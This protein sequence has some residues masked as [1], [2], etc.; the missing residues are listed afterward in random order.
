[1]KK[2]LWITALLCP[3]LAH[4]QVKMS[5]H[6]QVRHPAGTRQLYFF[7]RRNQIP[8]LIDS[9]NISSDG[10]YI[11]NLHLK[12]EGAYLVGDRMGGQY[13]FWATGKDL[14]MD[15]DEQEMPIVAN[16][17]DNQIVHQVN[18]AIA[19]RTKDYGTNP[20]QALQSF[21]EKLTVLIRANA[22]HPGVLYP[23]S[24]FSF[25]T[26]SALIGEILPTL[27]RKNPS[28]A[29]V[30]A[31]AAA[32]VRLQQG[33]PAP[34]FDFVTP[35]GEKKKL[36]AALT[37]SK[38]VLVDFWASWCG[39]CR[40]GIPGIKK[41]YDEYKNKGLDVLAI[42]LDAKEEE[43]K[44]ALAE[45]E[46][47]WRQGRV[48]DKGVYLMET[49]RF[50][51]IP[52][53]ALFDQQ[54]KIVTV[55]VS[56]EALEKK[57]LELMG[58]PDPVAATQTEYSSLEADDVEKKM[59]TDVLSRNLQPEYE[60][61]LKGST[62]ESFV[63]AYTDQL[64]A[65]ADLKGF[66][67]GK[68]F[69]SL[70]D[71]Y[72]ELMKLYRSPV[73]DKSREYGQLEAKQ[74]RYLRYLFNKPQYEKYLRY[75][76]DHPV[77]PGAVPLDSAVRTGKLP[78][79][80]TYYIRRNDQPKNQVLMYLVN[81]VGSILEQEHERGLA[82][83]MEHMNFNGTRHFP[84]NRLVTYLQKAGVR[85]G[86]DLNAYTSFDETVYEL[87]LST[88]DPSLVDSGLYVMRDWANA[89]TLDSLEIEKERGVV[90]EEKR[91]GKG[92]TER[93]RNNFLPIVT[94]QS[95]YAERLP[96][97]TDMVLKNFTRKDLVQFH[98]NWY[99]PDLQALIVVGDIDVDQM[100][101]TV[102]SMFADLLSA[103]GAP[104]RTH[105]EVPLTG[106]NQFLAQTDPDLTNTQLQIL[107]KQKGQQISS[108]ADFIASMKRTLFNSMLGRRMQDELNPLPDPGFT[109]I[110]A[111]V[112]PLMGGLDAFSYDVT[113]KD[114]MLKQ[115]VQQGWRS[116]T[117]VTKYGF[118]PAELDLARLSYLRSLEN[119]RM[120]AS[121]TPSRSY[122]SEYQAH[123]LHGTASPGLDWEYQFAKANI[124]ALTVADINALIPYYI[125]STNQDI[126]IQ[127]PDKQ[128]D[129]LPDEVAVRR[130]LNE[131]AEENLEP[132]KEAGSPVKSLLDHDPTP[133]KIVSSRRNKQMGT[134]E[135]TLSN[136]IKVVL[137]P[138]RFKNDEISYN[139]F[140]PGGT[141]RY[142]DSIYLAATLSAR[143]LSGFGIG[144]F[145]PADLARIL[146]DKIVNAGIYIGPRSQGI[147]GS[148]STKDLE[149]ALQLTYL[150]FTSPRADSQL[151]T[152]A[153]NSMK[154]SL[155]NRYADPSNVFSDTI[156]NF[157]SG[158][159]PRS[160]TPSITQVNR[161]KLSDI[162][163][164]YRDRFADADGFTFIFAGNIDSITIRPLL[165]KYLGSLPSLQ[166]KQK[167][168]DYKAT[169]PAGR[170]TKQVFKGSEEKATVRIM[171]GGQ[172]NLTPMNRLLLNAMGEV[173][174][175]RLLESLREEAGEVYSPS[176]RTST[177]KYPV[178]RFGITIS[179]GCAPVNV[180]HLVSLVEKAMKKLVE[181]GTSAEDLQK[182]KTAF[183]K[184]TEAALNTNDF[185]LSYLSTQYE[186][187]EDVAQ[188]NH[189]REYLDKLTSASFKKAAAHYLS[190]KNMIRFVLLPEKI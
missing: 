108:E 1:M 78:N 16:D 24:F 162:V 172:D 174:Q 28:N 171:L 63:K 68:L 86:A 185:W 112:Q 64:K 166:H 125:G 127:A 130:W 33:S 27:L 65:T 62:Q 111:S 161:V 138:T 152:N 34:D 154:A 184:Q 100:E 173:L 107:V 83:F 147:F 14:V 122:V 82:H 139:A 2:L 47:T 97:G 94:N 37:G 20:R 36:S 106:K 179:F 66:Q 132:V 12:R 51:G 186:N 81:K 150:Q 76:K 170:I 178:S 57:F 169:V 99:R 48:L 181:D 70:P 156:N 187:G 113:A 167:A 22:T 3:P 5:V 121:K 6:G 124:G 160:A 9:A 41:L 168:I 117:R 61:A 7:E 8:V 23:L 35:T 71:Y 4:A 29:A 84:G 15:I 136:G 143:L 18:L 77:L 103:P 145:S 149:T 30:K 39:P 45:E 158:Y 11:A 74:L 72:R 95:R 133:G 52:Y 189:Y 123:F 176:V 25:E 92:A 98:R 56:H 46:M 104:P 109:S 32:A 155:I 177:V 137:K 49:Y 140:A 21:S 110:R 129:Q 31:Y 55:N 96:I 157:M 148:A 114:G 163:S 105:Y 58:P 73:A 175:Y 50:S 151:F 101:K 44:K 142:P 115:A 54:G 90:V 102:R 119:A 89:A 159:S 85:F 190:G 91:L 144:K 141:S 80:F 10:Q 87:P 79:G 183:I 188:I 93:L 128:K 59:I 116:L 182:F 165:E 180:D 126:L 60:T 53:L 17:T 88:T 118:T 40:S 43:W 13:A 67:A 26:D 42:S 69:Y 153:I 19:Q 131:V 146:N 38:Y 75:R 164:I 135:L 134:E 120:E